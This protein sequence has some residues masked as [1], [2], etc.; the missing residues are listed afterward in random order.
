MVDTLEKSISH[1][2]QE[3]EILSFTLHRIITNDL[4][5]QANRMQLTQQL[6]ST[7]HVSEERSLI[8]SLHNKK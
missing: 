8:G 4:H 5:P 6:L 2:A 3:M 1:R 7:F